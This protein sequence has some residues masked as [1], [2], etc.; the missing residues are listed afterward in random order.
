MT[1]IRFLR[2][3][4]RAIVLNKD[5]R[6]SVVIYEQRE[7]GRGMYHVTAVVRELGT[8]KYFKASYMG[9]FRGFFKQPVRPFEADE[10]LFREVDPARIRG[11]EADHCDTAA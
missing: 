5:P 7:L 11:L 2:D 3:K 6:F 1:V 4:A 8:G 9:G 10:P